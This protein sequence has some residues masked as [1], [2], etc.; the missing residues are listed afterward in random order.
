M[1]LLEGLLKISFNS[2]SVLKLNILSFAKRTNFSYSIG[3]LWIRYYKQ[4][5][6]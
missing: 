6:A 5:S 4:F 2:N 1:N 3:L